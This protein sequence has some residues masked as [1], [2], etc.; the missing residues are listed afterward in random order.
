[1]NQWANFN[2]T[3]QKASQGNV[4]MERPHLFTLGDNNKICKSTFTKFE[5]ISTSELL[6]QFRNIYNHYFAQMYSLI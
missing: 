3:R 2:Q 1:M 6:G 5:K 4:Q